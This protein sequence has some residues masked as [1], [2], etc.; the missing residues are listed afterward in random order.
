MSA[1]FVCEYLALFL[2]T[3]F[4]HTCSHMV[5]VRITLLMLSM[6]L[7]CL[8]NYKSTGTGGKKK[9]VRHC[10]HWFPER[11]GWSWNFVSGMASVRKVL[12][13]TSG[14]CT[15]ASS[16]LCCPLSKSSG[17]LSSCHSSWSFD[18]SSSASLFLRLIQDHLGGGST[19]GQLISCCTGNWIIVTSGLRLEMVHLIFLSIDGLY[20]LWD[21]EELL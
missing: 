6:G 2:F 3:H 1:L 13:E 10:S 20:I 16:M 18:S 17:K 19:I 9:R 15:C 5:S 8:S 12:E 11:S 7:W 21:L 14:F 4:D